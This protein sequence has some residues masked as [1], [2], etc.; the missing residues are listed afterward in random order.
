M[1]AERE[2]GSSTPAHATG[3]V[4]FV[5]VDDIAG[6]ATFRLR[7]DGDVSQ[8]A[9]SFGR[10]GQLVP[11]ELR[12]WPGAASD[13]PR[14]QVVAGFRRLAAI[15][16]LARERVLARMHDA[17]AEDDA[18][19]L[20]LS[21][22]L[23]H[24][25]LTGDELVALRDRLR[26]KGVASWAE[27]LVEEALVTAPVTADLREKF[28]AFLAGAERPVP[29]AA[30]SGERGGHDPLPG[31]FPL[32]ERDLSGS[33]LERPSQDG[34]APLP[35]SSLP[36]RGDETHRASSVHDGGDSP[37]PDPD[38]IGL[39]SPPS[40]PAG[41]VGIAC[42]ADEDVIEVTPEDLVQDL[43]IRLSGL[44]Q[45]LATAVEAWKDLPLGGRKV[46]VEQ[47]RYV[48]ALLPFM[49]AEE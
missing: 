32:G 16:L 38:A 20:A 22:A 29:L 28:H 3:A 49:E 2:Q 4:Q 35:V 15:R 23:L 36:G 37:G 45:D 18:W 5:A 8:L 7:H 11:V 25:P 47:A 46:L 34:V 27:E 43:A 14:W 48:A 30:E 10:L 33:A 17:L 21:E 39:L 26:E 19:G 6:D 1:A 9:T 44:N 42:Q 41:G 24:Q 40:P 12:R 13:G 31:L